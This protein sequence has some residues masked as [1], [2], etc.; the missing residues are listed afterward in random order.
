VAD[1]AETRAE[2]L[3][4]ARLVVTNVAYNFGAQLWLLA[5]AV[6]STPYIVSELGV[7]LYGLL[8]LLT[9]LMGY[10]AF[11]DLG[12]GIATVKYL[13]EFHA[14][15][16][17][18][19]VNRVVGTSI[20]AFLV[21][22]ALGSGAIA[23]AAPFLA[24]SVLGLSVSRVDLARTALYVAAL[25]FLVNMPLAAL[26]AIPNALQRLDLV[27]RRNVLFGTVSVGGTV[28]LLALGRGLL[29]VLLLNA[30]VGVVAALSFA[31]LS[32]QL[33]PGVSFAPRLHRETLR[34]LA[35]FGSL[36]FANQVATQT[37]YHV[38]KFL[39]GA[40]VSVSAVA[41]Y[42]IPAGIAQRLAALVA[43]VTG[44]YLPAASA[45]HG[46]EDRRRFA[47]LYFRA[48][49]LVALVVFSTGSLVFVFAEPLLRFWLG[50]RFAAESSDVL[51]VLAAGY[52]VNALSTIPAVAA[53][54]VGRPRVTTAF[55]VASGLLNVG[56][57]LVLI[58][59]FGIVGAAFAILANSLVLVPLFIVYVHRTVLD[60]SV[61]ELVRRS[62]M[63]P[64][65]A[66]VVSWVPMLLLARESDSLPVL[67][68]ALAAG[69]AAYA[70]ATVLLS[71][72]DAVDRDVARSYF[73][74]VAS[75]S[76]G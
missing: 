75:G 54:S 38:D 1:P 51:R 49:K 65:A 39:V 60:L 56:L 61:G 41:Y 19:A 57:S 18:G 47:E 9:A 30:L 27:N 76:A 70:A 35:G 8:A 52:V 43:N 26:A 71:V 66:A 40:L 23:L 44:A 50:A 72:Y 58:P 37:V 73:R 21:L 36:K 63:R 7:E 16:D 68:A 31:R 22:G 25:G 64:F 67:L 12:L 55:S 24:E 46:Q 14:R 2:G 17:R 28:A 53:D 10:F 3:R 13:A 6:V 62:L 15:G 34:L 33:M 48:T 32:R 74:R 11:L 69:F 4:H 5:L 20:G 59:A 45:L 42:A 29:A